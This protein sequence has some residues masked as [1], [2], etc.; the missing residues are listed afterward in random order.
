MARIHVKE[1]RSSA[2]VAE[3]Q[4]READG[5]KDRAEKRSDE[6]AAL[7]EKLRQLNYITD[8]NLARHAWDENNVTLAGELLE[9]HRP[10]AAKRTYAALNGIISAGCSTATCAR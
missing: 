2:A 7:N 3:N 4:K 5:A 9:R 8:M 6:L 1:R 10:S